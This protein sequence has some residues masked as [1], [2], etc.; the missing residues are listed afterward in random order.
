[1][2]I[3][4]IS[5]FT[6]GAVA[7]GNFVANFTQYWI[8]IVVLSFP[9]SLFIYAI[10]DFYDGLSDNN[11]YR[12]GGIYGEKHSS[13]SMKQLPLWSLIGGAISMFCFVFYGLEIFTYFVVLS[14]FLY[15][16]SA[17]PIR[18]KSRPVFD[19]AIGGGYYGMS[20]GILGYLIFG[21]NLSGFFH[22]FPIVFVFQFIISSVAHII[23]AVIDLEA[24]KSQ[25]IQTSPVTFGPKKMIVVAISLLVIGLLL[26]RSNLFFQAYLFCALII[27]L[28]FLSEKLRKNYL[29]NVAVGGTMVLTYF[30]IAVIS[31]IFYPELIL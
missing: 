22:S 23:V 11:N 29:L 4:H 13:V 17:P 19:W 14:I 7:S 27:S 10:N 24:D 3:V 18:L 26:T 5:L 9:F 31:G 6:I 8:P 1:M 28:L 12:K 20:L 25:K 2:W 15:I 30:I 21:G 16:Y